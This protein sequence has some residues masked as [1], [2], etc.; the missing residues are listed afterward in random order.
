MADPIWRTQIR[1]TMQNSWKW[2]SHVG[3]GILLRSD[4]F[5]NES[6]ILYPPSWILKIW[7]RIR[8][9]ENLQKY[10]FICI[11]FWISN[12]PHFW[13]RHLAFWK[14]DRGF[15]ISDPKNPWVRTLAWKLWELSVIINFLQ[16]NCNFSTFVYLYKQNHHDF[17]LLYFNSYSW[18]Y[19]W[20]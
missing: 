9:P 7:P 19:N 2:N 20:Y 4:D 15:I 16:K 3:I 11:V 6:I 13:I 10:I 1:K 5:S 17:E 8:D 14:F 18:M 12:P